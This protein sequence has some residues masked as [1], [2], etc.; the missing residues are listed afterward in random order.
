MSDTKSDEDS[1]LAPLGHAFQKPPRLVRCTID[2]SAYKEFKLRPIK[3]VE[4]PQPDRDDSTNFSDL[5]MY[6]RMN[7]DDW[8]MREGGVL[9]AL[10]EYGNFFNCIY[11]Y[12][13]HQ[14]TFIKGWTDLFERL[15]SSGYCKNIIPCMVDVSD[16][17]IQFIMVSPLRYS[18][19]AKGMGAWIETVCSST[20]VKPCLPIATESWRNAERNSIISRGQ[21]IISPCFVP[22]PCYAA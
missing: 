5:M 18:F 8:R 15:Q 22:H 10:A 16:T 6:E 17:S 11:Y 9:Y 21:T 12:H 19:L 1:E 20:I 13:T 2:F 7:D 4:L 3:D 14:R